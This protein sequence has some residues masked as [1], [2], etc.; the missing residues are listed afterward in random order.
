M[1]FRAAATVLLG[2]QRDAQQHMVL[3][4]ENAISHFHLGRPDR[5][6]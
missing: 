6:S 2:Y 4:L 3:A 5:L 1:K